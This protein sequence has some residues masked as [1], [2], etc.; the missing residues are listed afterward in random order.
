[1]KGSGMSKGDW[2][3]W[4]VIVWHIVWCVPLWIVRCLFVLAV[5]M[6]SMSAK[7]IVK[8]WEVTA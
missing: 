3:P 1:M 8:A 6:F 5:G 2:F 4:Y 7:Q